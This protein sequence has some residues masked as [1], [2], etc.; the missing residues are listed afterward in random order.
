VAA[1][2]NARTKGAFETTARIGEEMGDL[3]K[4]NVE[5]IVASSKV[6]I[7]GA[8]AIGREATEFGQRRLEKAAAA[9]KSFAAVKSPARVIHAAK[10]LCPIIV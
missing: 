5:A 4:G 6:A 1:D 10:R 3:A 7:E 9:F 2:L 8:E